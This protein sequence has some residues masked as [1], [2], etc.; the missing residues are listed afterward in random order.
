MSSNQLVVLKFGGSVLASEDELPNAVHEIYRWVSSGH[1]VVAV[2]SALGATTNE[3]FERSR[4]YGNRLTPASV[5][6]LASTGESESASLLG[7]A[8]DRIGISNEVHDETS[9]GIQTIGESLDSSISKIDVDAVHAALGRSSVVV[10]PGFVGR[11]NRSMVNLLGRGGSDLT[12]LFIA[13]AIDAQKCI[14]IKDVEGLFEWDPKR[15]GSPRQF[16]K[17]TFANALTL[18]DTIVQ[19][20]AIEFAQNADVPFEVGR[21]RSTHSTE[22]GNFAEDVFYHDHR[23]PDPL[24][25]GLLG[26]GTVGLG[27]FRHLEKFTTTRVERIAVRDT[28]KAIANGAPARAVTNNGVHVV[29]EDVDIVVE[30]MGGIEPALTLVRAA[31]ESG[32]HVITANKSLI[33]RHGNELADMARSRDVQ[34]LY[35]AAVGGGVPMIEAVRRLADADPIVEIEGVLNGTCNFVLDKIAH[36][37]SFSDAVLAAQ[38]EGFAE[39]DPSLDLDGTDAAEKLVIL[40]RA[41]GIDLDFDGVERTAAS[42]N[43]IDQWQKSKPQDEVLR[44][45]SKLTLKNDASDDSNSADQLTANVDVRSLPLNHVFAQ[46]HGEENLLVVKTESGKRIVLSGRGAGQFPTAQSVINDLGILVRGHFASNTDI[47]RS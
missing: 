38:R 46:V 28:E 31:L 43:L 23:R 47:S 35:S 34:L 11:D 36:R 8:M 9:L 40:G 27:V 45:V 6:K 20:K 33:A 30:L 18:D 24:R 2:V 15:S 16:R 41:A 29:G 42:E 37:V 17:I 3:L 44:Q 13:N 5:A 32:K 22:V 1:Q 7:L 12:A 26:M 10:V 14:L 19:H 25:V 39:A 4:K 21:L